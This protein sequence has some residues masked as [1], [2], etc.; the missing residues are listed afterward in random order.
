M[1]GDWIFICIGFSLAQVEAWIYWQKTE[2]IK[3]PAQ[4][5]STASLL[6]TKLT[7]HEHYKEQRM[8]LLWSKK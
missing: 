8:Q 5:Y 1:K 6:Q 2:Q 4:I 3:P 7:Q